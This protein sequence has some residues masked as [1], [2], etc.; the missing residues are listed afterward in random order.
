MNKIDVKIYGDGK[1][2]KQYSRAI[3]C[4]NSRI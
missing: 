4:D 1:R 2:E 3:Y